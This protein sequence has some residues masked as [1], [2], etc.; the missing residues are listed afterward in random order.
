V[1]RANADSLRL[2]LDDFQL[3]NGTYK[4]GGASTFNE[5]QLGT[6][7]GWSPDGDN[8]AYTYTV[9]ARTT[10]WDINVLHTSSTNWMR[11]EDRMN[12]CCSGQGT[13][14]ASCP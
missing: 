8:D 10:S 7:F 5:A 4:A 13:P 12:S 11:C 14:P 2:F 6:N 9:T 3:N 1:A